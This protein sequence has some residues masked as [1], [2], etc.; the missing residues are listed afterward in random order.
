MNKVNTTVTSESTSTDLERVAIS[1]TPLH[2]DEDLMQ[3][4]VRKVNIARR[5]GCRKATIS[6]SRMGA[7]WLETHRTDVGVQTTPRENSNNVREIFSSRLRRVRT[8]DVGYFLSNTE[9]MGEVRTVN[10]E[11]GVFS[12]E[13]KNSGDTDECYLVEFDLDEV[14]AADRVL[15]R[16]GAL[17]FWEVGK[18]I[19][20]GTERNVSQILFRRMASIGKRQ[21]LKV[22]KNAR[23][24]A[25]AIRRAIIET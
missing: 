7:E 25:D 19:T 11:T 10:V 24:E 4:F 23:D 3:M 8:S 21:L 2:D 18:E 6:D 13:V 17:F 22:E 20:N 12:A 1:A 14:P 16:N 15:V 5:M 9:F